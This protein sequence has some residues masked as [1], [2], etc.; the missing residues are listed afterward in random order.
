MALSKAD[1]LLSIGLDQQTAA[2]LAANGWTVSKLKRAKTSE[3][4]VLGISKE[5]RTAL[6]RPP[7]A[8]DVLFK[9]L[10]KSKRTCCVCRDPHHP[11]IV[12]HIEE[13]HETRDHA[14][15]NLAV[16][17]LND[18][19]RA[20]T[21]SKLSQNLTPEMIRRHKAEW[22]EQVRSS[23]AN[24][25]L[26]LSRVDGANWDYVNI[27]RVFRLA[28]QLNIDLRTMPR[29]AELRSQD[30]LTAS[31]DV[32]ADVYS[33]SHPRPSMY[34]SGLWEGR[35]LYQYTS[36]TLEAL[37]KRLG[38]VDVTEVTSRSELLELAEDGI[39]IFVQAPFYFRRDSKLNSGAGQ[40]RTAYTKISGVKVQFVFDAWES[41]SMSAHSDRLSGRKVE[42][43]LGLVNGSDYKSEPPILQISCLGMGSYFQRVHFRP[44]PA[45]AEDPYLD[46]EEEDLLASED[47]SDE[48]TPKST[49]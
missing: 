23:D 46:E 43:V 29:F 32:H 28:N 35:M 26:G 27:T 12:H 21:I 6:T 37:I 38:V 24:S 31:G 34:L 48:T 1:K 7:I 14:E 45:I 36:G 4:D 22:E 20:H 16:L 33:P 40:M 5:V 2:Q 3:L 8:P 19:A 10:Y 30:L 18:H 41:T 17:C 44:F 11:I 9:V 25:I 39:L 47:R 42:S 15:T 13:W 49:N